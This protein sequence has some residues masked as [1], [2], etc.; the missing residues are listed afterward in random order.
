M[1]LFVAVGPALTAV[2]AIETYLDTLEIGGVRFLSRM[3]PS[4]LRRRE[5]K[6]NPRN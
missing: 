1:S 4:Y 3:L 6:G 5:A 2:E